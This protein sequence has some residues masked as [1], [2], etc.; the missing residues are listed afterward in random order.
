[1]KYVQYLLVFFAIG[2]LAA[3]SD[4]DDDHDYIPPAASAAELR[5]THAS[6]DAP[7]VNV[8][9]DGAL[10]LEAVDYKDSSG[11]LS[12]AA[13]D[14]EVEVRGILAD[15]S[16]LSVIGP[17]TLALSAETRTD[18]IAYDTLLAGEDINIKPLVLPALDISETVAQ[19]RVSIVHAAPAVADVDIYVSA[20]EDDIASVTPIDAGFGDVAGP[21]DLMASTEYRVRITP[22]GSATVVYDSGTL[23]FPAGTDLVVAAVENTTGVGDNPVNLLAIGADGAAEVLDVVSGSNAEIRVVHNSADTPAVDLLVNGNKA[24]SGLTF[25]NAT[26]YDELSAP[27]GTYNVVVAAT[28][29]NTIAPISADLSVEAAKSYTTVAIGA[30]NGITDNT[31]SAVVT[32]DARRDVAT[33]ALLRVIHGSFAVAAEIPVD[34]YLT[35]TADISSAG[36]AVSALAYGEFTE[37]LA[38]TPGEYV[39]TVTAAGDKSVVAFSSGAAIALDGAGN[40]TVIARDPAAGED[41]GSNLV[42]A[43]ILTD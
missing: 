34:V 32:Q 26:M 3:C 24:L 19:V 28:T 36:A 21:V 39:I 25:P 11:I 16:E 31:L 17:T 8:Y 43:T 40:Y 20:P 1:M 14:V 12:R 6:P 37:Q 15:G 7:K 5:V 22:D 10:A 13:G 4:D 35:A 9:V 33:Q 29:D 23:S 30:L 27:A 18:V 2:G 42:L 41:P 38:V